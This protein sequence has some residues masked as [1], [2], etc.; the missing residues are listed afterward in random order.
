MKETVNILS[1]MLSNLWAHRRT[2]YWVVPTSLVVVYLIMMLVPKRYASE[3][4]I[5]R[6][7]E[8]AVETNRVMTF[9]IPENYDLGLTKTDNAVRVNGYE[10]IVRSP[11][12][13]MTLFDKEVCSRNAEYQGSYAGYIDQHYGKKWFR[14]AAPDDSIA[15]E[16]GLSRHQVNVISTMRKHISCTV[17]QRTDVITVRVETLDPQV[18]AQVADYVETGLQQFIIDYKHDKMQSVVD[19]L[20]ERIAAADSAW[21]EAVRTG[22]AQADVKKRIYD[23]FC[24]QRVVYEAQMIDYPSF[25]TLSSPIISYKAV[26]P[27]RMLITI[28]MTMLISLAYGA[29]LC[30]KEIAELL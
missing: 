30:R 13:L 12:F 27:H 18:S 8:Q 14:Q 26:A 21:Q 1:A 16:G 23:S 17:D 29:W 20:D 24:R 28:L 25:V 15:Y 22:D 11:R 4:T 19:Q 7:T 10:E 3:F 6:E 5:M 9:N 2:F